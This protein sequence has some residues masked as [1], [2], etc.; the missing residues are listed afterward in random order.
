MPIIKKLNNYR[1]RQKMAIF[2]YDWT[3]VKPKSNGTFSKDEN[4]WSMKKC[5]FLY[6]PINH[7]QK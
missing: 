1:F 4:D 2:D 7:H 5:S 6:L 3:L